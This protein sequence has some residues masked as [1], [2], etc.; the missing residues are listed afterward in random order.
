MVLAATVLYYHNGT[1]MSRL[2]SKKFLYILSSRIDEKSGTE[3]HA[4]D[5]LFSVNAVAALDDIGVRDDREAVAYHGRADSAV[6]EE[7]E[8]PIVVNRLAVFKCLVCLV[9]AY[10]AHEL[11]AYAAVAIKRVAVAV[12]KAVE[13]AVG[14]A[15]DIAADKEYSVVFERL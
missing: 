2:F 11:E 10:G 4:A 3:T 7:V 9:I 6:G 5:V 14:Q 12:I 13:V 15:D 1:E 8:D